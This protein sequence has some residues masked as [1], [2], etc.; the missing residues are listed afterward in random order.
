MPARLLARESAVAVVAAGRKTYNLDAGPWKR[1]AKEVQ[2]GVLIIG[3]LYWDDSGPRSVWRSER[4]DRDAQQ[5]VR[6]PIRYGRRA[7]KRGNTY[8]MVFSSGLAEG[9]FGAAI[10]VPFKSKDLLEE[11]EH[12]W[13]AERDAANGPNGRISAPW[14]GVALLE[15]PMVPVHRESR[16]GWIARVQQEPRYG[17]LEHAQDEARRSRQIRFLSIDWPNT[18]NGS[19]LEWDALL[20]AATCPTLDDG[21][22][23]SSRNIADA[24]NTPVGRNEVK[25]LRNNRAHGI[26]TFQD[27]EIEAHL[28]ELGHKL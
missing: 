23:P 25:Y 18:V 14:G 15:N 13:A 2:I 12:L 7:M 9:Q 17:N 28:R 11:A 19:P 27:T 20:A 3:S 21:E 8:T 4:L 10:A 26:T 24:W 22:Y 6:A 1:V 5:R 16:E